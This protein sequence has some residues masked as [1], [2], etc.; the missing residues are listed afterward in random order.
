MHTQRKNPLTT[1]L[2]EKRFSKLWFGNGVSRLALKWNGDGGKGSGVPASL[3]WL[4]LRLPPL[5]SPLLFL[6]QMVW[7]LQDTWPQVRE[8]GGQAGGKGADGQSGH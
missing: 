3:P 8:D 6:H 5:M 2:R 7:P 1:P 4:L